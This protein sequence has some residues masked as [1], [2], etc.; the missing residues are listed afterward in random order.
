MKNRYNIGD[1][2]CVIFDLTMGGYDGCYCKITKVDKQK[3]IKYPCLMEGEDSL[4]I[5]MNS[6]E[7]G[8]VVNSNGV[9]T[10]GTTSESWATLTLFT[11]TIELSN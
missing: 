5:L 10:L 2:C 11:G 3:E 4:V 6:A 1:Y 8:T 9:W 7:R